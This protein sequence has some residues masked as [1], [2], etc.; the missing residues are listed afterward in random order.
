VA[1]VAVA[2]TG[3]RIAP[4]DLPESAQLRL[5]RLHPKA[6]Y[7][8]AARTVVVPRPVD[9]GKIGGAALRDVALLDWCAA[10]LEDVVAPVVATV[11]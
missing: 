11:G 3:I 2:A 5:K 10:V 1:E 7:K 9:G 6:T 8:A 4:V